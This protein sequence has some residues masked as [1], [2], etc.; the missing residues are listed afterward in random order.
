[1]AKTPPLWTR[2]RGGTALRVRGMGKPETRKRS[3]QRQ[4]L[5]WSGTDRARLRVRKGGNLSTPPAAPLRGRWVDPEKPRPHAFSS[6]GGSDQH[7]LGIR[8]SALSPSF[9]DEGGV[10]FQGRG[11]PFGSPHPEEHLAIDAFRRRPGN[12]SAIIRDPL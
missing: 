6:A 8:G 9:P 4:G 7:A 12:R 5:L 10:Q 11:A 3:R 2:G 1:M